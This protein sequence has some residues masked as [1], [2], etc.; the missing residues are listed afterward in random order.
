M[1]TELSAIMMEAES[2]RTVLK[3]GGLGKKRVHTG[4]KK[5]ERKQENNF[6]TCTCPGVTLDRLCKGQ[7]RS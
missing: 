1:L 5:R 2:P 4:K 7:G 3:R 6:A